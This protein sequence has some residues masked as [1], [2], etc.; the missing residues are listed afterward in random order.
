MKTVS[1]I[2]PTYNERD[3]I[4]ELIRDI[5][6]RISPE[7]EIVVVD[8]DSPDGTG[9]IV[10]RL[11]LQDPRVRLLR[12][13]AKRGLTLSLKTGIK[14]AR[15]QTVIWMDAD[16][17]HPPTLLPEL[18]RQPEDFDIVV[19]SRYIPGGS[20]GRKSFLR[21][22]IS[23]TLNRVGQ[24]FL[25][26]SVRDLTSGYLRVKKN[27]F[28]GVPLRGEYGDYCIDFLARAEKKGFKIK[29]IPFTNAD[30][31]E[32]YSKTT[33]NPLIFFSYALIYIRTLLRLRRYRSD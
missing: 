3:N 20:D 26:S 5:L 28:H 19:A 27:V 22:G 18:I 11:S 2:L 21:R 32:G 1:I 29:E 10:S 16:F 12:R 8:D 9:E 6:S 4:E 33:S 7:S 17:A 13:K 24:W 15:H 14:A 31:E 25:N 23:F 30:R